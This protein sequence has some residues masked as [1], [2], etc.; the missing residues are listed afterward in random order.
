MAASPAPGGAGLK[1]GYSPPYPGV[2]GD[3]VTN[4]VEWPNL[5]EYWLRTEN[6]TQLLWAPEFVFPDAARRCL[7]I[8]W[9]QWQI[10]DE[11]GKVMPVTE[12]QIV[13]YFGSLT[14]SDLK[15]WHENYW[16]LPA[17][18]R[19]AKLEEAGIELPKDV[20]IRGKLLIQGIPP[21]I[22]NKFQFPRATAVPVRGGGGAGGC[23]IGSLIRQMAGHRR[24]S[25]E[26]SLYEALIR[27]SMA[28]QLAAQ[29]FLGWR[30]L[31]QDLHFKHSRRHGFRTAAIDMTATT[32]TVPV[33]TWNKRVVLRYP[34]DVDMDLH[35]VQRLLLG[36]WA[37]LRFNWFVL[38]IRDDSSHLIIEET[39]HNIEVRGAISSQDAAGLY[40]ILPCCGSLGILLLDRM[41]RI[42]MA[43]LLEKCTPRQ[44]EIVKTIPKKV[45]QEALVLGP[46]SKACMLYLAK[47]YKTDHP[48]Y[49][50]LRANC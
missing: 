3:I 28:Q 27:A 18:K 42:G 35:K 44:K 29:G 45:I 10:F 20:D 30:D 23:D 12:I 17:T 46:G 7:A 8:R 4:N 2:M 37:L 47:S 31:L 43:R 1:E 32:V 25:A 49:R 5:Y 39:A 26:T 19:R 22:L 9:L 38:Q 11:F 16:L 6:C 33:R 21:A 15:W 48:H 13:H 36:Q 24:T 50:E 40:K 41:E 34:R 14:S